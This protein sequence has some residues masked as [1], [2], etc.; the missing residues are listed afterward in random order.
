M[1]TLDWHY[2]STLSQLSKADKNTPTQFYVCDYQGNRVRTVV[3]STYLK[4]H[5]MS[6]KNTQQSSLDDV[7]NIINWNEIEQTLSML[8]S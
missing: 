4:Q 5:Q 8:Y 1:G 3:E 7:H 6:W 2:N